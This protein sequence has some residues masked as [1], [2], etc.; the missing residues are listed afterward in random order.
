MLTKSLRLS[1][2][3][4]C[5]RPLYGDIGTHHAQFPACGSPPRQF[6]QA[7]PALRRDS[8]QTLARMKTFI[9][10]FAF[11]LSVFSLPA[12]AC[13]LVTPKSV[14]FD[15]SLARPGERPPETPAIRVKDIYRGNVDDPSGSCGDLGVVTLSVPATRRN[16]KLLYSFETV[17]GKV[18]NNIFQH[19]PSTGIEIDGELIFVFP[20]FDG[21]TASQEPIDLV[22]RVVPYSKSGLAGKGLDLVFHDPGR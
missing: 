21:A 20:W 9:T 4:R 8:T 18:D 12:S 1:V 7:E 3:S 14:A 22:V 10:T 2:K 15:S 13:S 17:S 19:G 11:I 6:I 16:K 5:T